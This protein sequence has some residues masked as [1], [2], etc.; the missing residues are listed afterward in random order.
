VRSTRLPGVSPRLGI[1]PDND[2]LDKLNGNAVEE[3]GHRK[4]NR[5]RTVHRIRATG[6]RGTRR[7]DHQIEGHEFIAVLRERLAVEWQSRRYAI[8]GD[9]KIYNGSRR[10]AHVDYVMTWKVINPHAQA[11][12]SMPRSALTAAR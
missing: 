6:H 3:L 1:W 5:E 4:R 10:T 11:L 7:R 12:T 2:K 8:D 9:P